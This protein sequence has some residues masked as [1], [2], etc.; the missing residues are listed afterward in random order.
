MI[1]LKAPDGTNPYVSMYT[2]L[3]GRT[4]ELRWAHNDRSDS[5]TLSVGYL[6]GTEVIPV[7]VGAK[8]V[9]GRDLLFR[10]RNP[11]KPEGTIYVV[12]NDGS[13]ERPRLTDFADR[14][15]VLY[16]EPGEEA[17]IAALVST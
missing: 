14:C 9:Q 12:A 15:S 16:L 3:T 6:S 11:Y 4:F 17:E 10:N 5:W 13:R 1:K 2:V 7:L 8:L